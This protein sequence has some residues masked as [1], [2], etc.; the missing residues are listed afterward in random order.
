MVCVIR[1]ADH[2]V[3]RGA[4]PE[5]RGSVQCVCGLLSAAAG[6]LAGRGGGGGGGGR[7]VVPTCGY[8]GRPGH[9]W[10]GMPASVHAARRNY[11][12]IRH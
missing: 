11:T 12:L 5:G 1:T 8:T 4:V 3:G 2:D 9:V 10:V 7:C 6:H